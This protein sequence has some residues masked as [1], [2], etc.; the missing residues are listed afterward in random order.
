MK[1]LITGLCLS[2][3][4]GGAAMALTLVDQVKQ[5]HPDTEFIFAIDP[6]SFNQERYWAEHYGL[7]IIR[8]D[9]Y[10]SYFFNT[11]TLL[12]VVRFLYRKIMR[13]PISL[14]SKK[15]FKELHKEF[16][17]CYQDCDL[18]ISM[19][20]ISYVGDG[21]RGRLEGLL[22]YS[23][24][25]YA[26]KNKKPFAHFV[27]SFG[28]FND[29]KV[30][31]FARKDFAYVPFIP[32]RGKE[33]AK[34]CQQIVRHP[35]KIYDFPDIAIL[36]PIA[37]DA[38][39]IDYLH[40]LGLQ[41]EQYLI[42]SPSSVI[43]HLPPNVG[44]S[45]GEKHIESFYLIARD[46]LSYGES[47]LFLGHMY[48]DDQNQCDREVSRKVI[49]CLKKKGHDI[50]KCKI[51]EEDINPWQAKALI[52]KSKLTVASR[53]HAIVAAVST[54]TPAIAI[55]WNV[56]YHDILDYY[57]IPS[58]AIDVRDKS[59]KE[60]A[61]FVLNKFKEYKDQDYRTILREKH[62]E[63]VKKVESAFNLLTAWIRNQV[64]AS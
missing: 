25:Y 22:S 61:R 64:K 60:I 32:A 55:G 4:L 29:W 38:W 10:V 15:D 5:R 56:K 16:M 19:R 43:Y 47:I 3:N 49:Q 58:M 27:Q 28:P 45:T 23:D 39:T 17:Q 54:S 12:R 53:Y 35:E 24:L 14:K 30:R 50:S 1:C 2:R 26:K 57:R 21:T 41:E 63:N 46:L 7:R 13:K 51:V 31:Y 59:P 42:L 9:N 18:I 52:A 62:Q 6:A 20:G 33:S 11:N 36:L 48:S 40:H 8:G 34:Y 37:E 44:G